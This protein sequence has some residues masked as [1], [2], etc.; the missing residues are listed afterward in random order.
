VFLSDPGLE[1]KICEQQDLV[2]NEI[3]DLGEFCDLLLFVSYFASQNKE[4]VEFVL[5]PQHET[6]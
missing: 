2:S 5:H 3:S 6:C 4:I 1:S